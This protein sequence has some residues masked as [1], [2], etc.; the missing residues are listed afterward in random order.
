MTPVYCTFV[1]Y[2]YLRYNQQYD[3]DDGFNPM[4]QENYVDGILA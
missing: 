2:T 1:D 3:E 4:G